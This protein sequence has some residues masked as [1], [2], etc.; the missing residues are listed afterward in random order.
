MPDVGG[1][2]LSKGELRPLRGR[3][4]YRHES[5]HL[6]QKE[7]VQIMTPP[8]SDPVTLNVNF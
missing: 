5:R 4:T 3:E 8:L 6:S 2:G 7:S 1:G